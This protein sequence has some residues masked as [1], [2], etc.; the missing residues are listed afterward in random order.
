MIIK[1]GDTII[2]T[3][4]NYQPNN[5]KLSL[6]AGLNIGAHI[7]TIKKGF[8]SQH[9]ASCWP[10]NFHIAFKHQLLGNIHHHKLPTCWSSLRASNSRH[11]SLNLYLK[12]GYL[13]VVRR[14]SESRLKSG[15]RAYLETQIRVPVSHHLSNHISG[16]RRDLNAMSNQPLF[17][18]SWI[19]MVLYIQNMNSH[20]SLSIDHLRNCDTN[21]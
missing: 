11:L 14:R 18:L 6:L 21:S 3:V 10:D 19:F 16:I 1:N 8:I 9:F 13:N 12:S 15:P 4:F 2:V 17:P 20:I 7:P 5:W